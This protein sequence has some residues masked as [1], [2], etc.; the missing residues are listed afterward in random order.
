MPA[1]NLKLAASPDII[2]CRDNWLVKTSSSNKNSVCLV[3][4][5]TESDAV[6][7]RYFTKKSVSEDGAALSYIEKVIDG[8]KEHEQKKKLQRKR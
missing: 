2:E 3:M 4:Y 6:S 1:K 5:N 8:M 7:I